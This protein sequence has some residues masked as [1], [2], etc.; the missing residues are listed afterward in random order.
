MAGDASAYLRNKLVDHSLGTAAYTKPSAVYLAAYVG[1][2]GGAGAEVSGNGYERQA[3]VFGAASDGAAA[4]SADVTFPVASGAWG[5]V[6]HLAL[7]DAATAGNLLWYGPMTLSKT[8]EEGDQL[9][10]A[11]GNFTVTLV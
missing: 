8:I 1:D 7:F 2:P 3:M 4:S 6:S 5:T 9:K 10:V 11:S